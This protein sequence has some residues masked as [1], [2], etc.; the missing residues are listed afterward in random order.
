MADGFTVFQGDAAES[1]EYFRSFK[2]K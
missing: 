1:L 2:M